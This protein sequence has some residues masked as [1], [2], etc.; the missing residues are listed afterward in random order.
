[1]S[2]HHETTRR[3]GRSALDAD[4][5]VSWAEPPKPER[6]WKKTFLV[7][8]LAILSWVAT[9]VGMLEL[10]EANT[11]ELPVVHKIVIAGSVGMLMTMIVWLLD[12]MF[13]P[14]GTFTKLCYAAGY[15]FLSVISV[16]F[17]FGFYWKVL[18]S[19]GEGTRVAET[20]VGTVQAPLQTAASR[21]ESLGRTLDGLQQ[22]S[23]QKAEIER[24][25]GTS[26]P[27]SRPGDGPR[28]KLR[29]DDAS[30]FAFARDVVKTRIDAV[31]AD[32]AAIDAELAKLIKND[33]SIVD[34]HGTRNDFMKALNRRLDTTVTSFNAFRGDPQLKQIRTELDARAGQTQFMDTA[35]RPFACPDP[36]LV[37]MIRSV[38]ASIDAL[39]VLEK[40]KIATVEGSD[41][42]IE[43]FR[44][45]T[46]TMV[47]ALTFKL[48]PS[49]ED[50]RDLQKKA[51]ASADLSPDKRAALSAGSEQAGLS[52]RDYIPL[53]IAIFVD[54]CLLLVAMGQRT[55]R[56]D[57]L[58][59]KMQEA[60]RG[61]VH[62]ILS[63][64]NEIHRDPQVREE[65]ELFRHIVFE[66]HGDYYAAVP[67]DAPARMN[68]KDREA[69]RIDAHL[70]ANLFTSFEK[71]KIF[72]RV[73]MPYMTTRAIQKKLWQQGSKFAHS[74][75]FRLYKFKD[76][77]WS[78]MI[79]GAVMGA[80][81][82]VAAEKRR[83]RIEDDLFARHEPRFTGPV[84]H[85]AMRKSAPQAVPVTPR[86]QAAPPRAT[87]GNAAIAAGANVAPYP[88]PAPRRAEPAT[89]TGLA[90]EDVVADLGAHRQKLEAQAGVVVRPVAPAEPETEPVEVLSEVAPSEPRITVEAVERTMRFDVPTADVRLPQS[91]ESLL[92][93][94]IDRPRLDAVTPVR[95]LDE[96]GAADIARRL[97]P[98]TERP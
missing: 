46:A 63:R 61:P 66:M 87:F 68:P 4:D 55:N 89:Q 56:L 20:A 29:E 31:K 30:R 60:E 45:L 78:E 84:S 96:T 19:K 47:G 91:V 76:G 95:P 94:A 36:G 35:N 16:G 50:I 33:P 22:T 6:D 43:A 82:R 70:I 39:P 5:A 97:A 8:G 17:G 26:C 64:F 51:I 14:I 44:R 37:T 52:R 83:Q 53:A 10:I 34:A 3:T 54:V 75:S 2:D 11:G 69:L 81:K 41:A 23:A 88:Q 9:Y 59:P 72:S 77:A 15:L 18:E 62:Q 67:L 80:A 40:P 71:E 86:A 13:K 93:A 42:T 65:F 12:Q 57:G 38:V 48:P 32:I 73:L 98:R 74:D 24:T 85:D 90:T 58:V 7:V 1:M 25:Q 92:A 28:R 21:L 79:L 27:N 49:A